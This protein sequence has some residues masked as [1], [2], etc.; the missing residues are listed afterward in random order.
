MTDFIWLAPQWLWLLSSP[1]IWLVINAYRHQRSLIELKNFSQQPLKK[2]WLK[3]P[4][5]LMC[6]SLTFISLALAR[7]AW[8]PQA[9]GVNGQGRDIIFLLDVSRSMLAADARPNRLEVA[10]HAILQTVN[11]NKTDRYGLVAFAGAASILSPLT[12]DQAFF[13]SL[14]TS[15]NTDSVPQGGTRIEDALFKV[16]DK[17]IAKSSDAPAVDLILISDGE[18][19]G[20][21]PQRALAKLNQLGVRLIVIGLGDSQFGARIPNRD[22]QGWVFHQERELWSKLHTQSLRELST[23]ATQGMFFPVGT[24]SFDLGKIMTKLR[25]VWPGEKRFNNEIMQYTQGYPYCLAIAVLSLLILL[26]GNKN[27]LLAGLAMLSFTSQAFE[28]PSL[29]KSALAEVSLESTIAR[30][31]ADITQAELSER[32]LAALSLSEQFKQAEQLFIETPEQAIEAYRL[33]AEQ[34]SH[35]NVAIRATYNQATSLIAYG[36]LLSQQLE[37]LA[38]PDDIEA[39]LNFNVAAENFIDP[40]PYYREAADLLRLVLN[41][42]PSHS[43]SA[44]NLEWL[45]LRADNI[46]KANQKQQFQQQQSEQHQQSQDKKEQQQKSDADDK[47]QNNKKNAASN[48]ENG[49]QQQESQ[50]EDVD[51][52]SLKLPAPSSSA[53]DILQQAKQR[54]QQKRSQQ[55]KK[56][57]AVERDW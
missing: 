55:R 5:A 15:I 13:K 42:E 40:E 17:M 54:D 50:Q 1:L 43:A 47:S 9:E 31:E 7:P 14:L 48:D 16:L 37:M 49:E 18:D 26:L 8:N 29:Q 46:N 51:M 45:A 19:L 33:I 34:T 41:Q 22:G 11:A 6:I 4:S 56:Q 27:S 36:E 30:D 24:A 10:R 52:N 28:Q 20:S 44:K 32:P 12:N 3:L 2:H 39:L 25:Q 38:D 35:F 23:A 53:E 21:K 57:N